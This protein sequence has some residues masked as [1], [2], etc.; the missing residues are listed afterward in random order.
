MKSNLISKSSILA[1]FIGAILIVFSATDLFLIH[2]KSYY[3]IALIFF[4][5]L[6]L[7][8]RIIFKSEKLADQQSLR[9]AK[10][11][12]VYCIM[13]VLSSI[14]YYVLGT[15]SSKNI[16][17]EQLFIAILINIGLGIILSFLNA[18]STKPK[19]ATKSNYT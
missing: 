16:E 15:L 1:G 4:A 19:S 11:F 8:Q 2:W 3:L 6:F 18:I 10:S 12:I 14:M 13:I 9:I 17:K 5:S 7:S